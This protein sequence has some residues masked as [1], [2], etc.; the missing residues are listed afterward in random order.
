M[1]RFVLSLCVLVGGAMVLHAQDVNNSDQEMR[2]RGNHH[3]DMMSEKLNLSDDQKTK[4][5]SIDED[6]H[7]QM[8]ELKKTDNITVKEWRTRMES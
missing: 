7:S 3:F 5:K 4:M 6:F 8:N 2:H 1:R